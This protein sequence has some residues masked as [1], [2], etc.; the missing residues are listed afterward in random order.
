MGNSQSMDSAKHVLKEGLS[1]CMTF[2]KEMDKQQQ[3]QQG[4][5]Q[6]G[7]QQQG[8]QQHQQQGQQQ[9]RPQ[10]SSS[11]HPP[12]DVDDDDEYTSLRRQAGEE[13]QKRNACYAESQEAYSSKNGARGEIFCCCCFCC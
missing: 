3:Q 13:A 5:Q 6:Q 1:F 11:Y 10:P 7:H 9:H 12:A 8:Q 2:K 4:H